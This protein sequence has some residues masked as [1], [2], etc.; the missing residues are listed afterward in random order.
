M[1]E[2]QLCEQL[3]CLRPVP[4]SLMSLIEI[5]KAWECGFY[6]NANIME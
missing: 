1:A 6:D 3:T 4:E 2:Q 5:L